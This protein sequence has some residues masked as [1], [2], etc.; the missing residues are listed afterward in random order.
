MT[1]A[2]EQHQ[3]YG[4]VIGGGYNNNNKMNGYNEQPPQKKQMINNNNFSM[5]IGMSEE[6]NRLTRDFLGVGEIVRSMNGGGSNNNP[7]GGGN[8]Q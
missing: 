7:F 1:G 4:G 8:F 6:A 2:Q 5:E 3:E